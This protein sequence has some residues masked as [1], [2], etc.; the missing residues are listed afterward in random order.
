MKRTSSLYRTTL[1]AL[2][3]AL[4]I[5]LPIGLHSIPKAGALLSPMHI[6]VLLCGIICG[7]YYGLLCG[8]LGPILSS[9]LTG[10]PVPAKLPGMIIELAIY[11]LA[12]GLILTIL[13]KGNQL[14]QIYI[15]LL[16]AMLLGRIVAGITQ[17]FLFVG[18]SYTWE[19]W[20]T[21]YFVTSFPGIL[22]Q[23][24]LIPIIY[25]AL[26]RTHLLPEDK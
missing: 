13:K 14:L 4:C 9:A 5:V 24:I 23:L 10:M 22:V 19:A 12:S 6:P 15:S 7:P 2:C 8:I 25:F 18:A 21:S 26:Q 1:A 17:A 11:G 16:A 20:A 3:L